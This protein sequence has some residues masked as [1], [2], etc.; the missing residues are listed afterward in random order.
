MMFLWLIVFFF[1]LHWALKCFIVVCHCKAHLPPSVCSLFYAAEPLAVWAICNHALSTGGAFVHPLAFG[2]QLSRLAIC[3]GKKLGHLLVLY[4]LSGCKGGFRLWPC[5]TTVTTNSMLCSECTYY[6]E[7]TVCWMV[8]FGL[9]AVFYRCNRHCSLTTVQCRKG[10][11]KRYLTSQLFWQLSCLMLAWSHPSSSWKC[12]GDSL[13]LSP[14]QWEV[15][16]WNCLLHRKRNNLLSFWGE[17]LVLWGKRLSFWEGENIAHVAEG[18][19]CSCY[20]PI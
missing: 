11:G 10:K 3:C 17:T 12:P 4:H 15:Y 2:Q 1:F 8:Q 5:S 14:C 16:Y 13:L 6:F 18:K 20:I 9:S 7:C 19:A